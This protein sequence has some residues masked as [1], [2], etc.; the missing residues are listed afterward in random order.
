M[1]FDVLRM[2]GTS[3]MRPNS[4]IIVVPAVVLPVTV[5]PWRCR[6][7]A[8]AGQMPLVLSHS[9]DEEH[10]GFAVEGEILG[11]FSR[12]IGRRER[13]EPFPMFHPA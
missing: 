1:L 5:G 6:L 8:M 13:P 3:V 11:T 10:L 4:L 7:C 9:G 2:T 12:R